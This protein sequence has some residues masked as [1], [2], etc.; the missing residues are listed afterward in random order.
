M[1]CRNTLSKSLLVSQNAS[2]TKLQTSKKKDA[3]NGHS[4][5][6]K[7]HNKLSHSPGKENCESDVSLQPQVKVVDCLLADV[8]WKDKKLSVRCSNKVRL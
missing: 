3:Q 4:E 8:M 7:A 6:A 1:L 5:E 2:S